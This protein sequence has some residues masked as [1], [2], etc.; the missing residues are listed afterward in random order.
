M[1]NMVK[2]MRVRFSGTEQDSQQDPN[3]TRERR[4]PPQKTSSF[5]GDEKKQQNWFQKQFSR[6]SSRDYDPSD[7]GEYAT[8]IAAA[9]FAINSLEEAELVDK[10]KIRE[11]SEKFPTKTNSKK[12]ESSKKFPTKTNSKK[13][14]GVAL[15]QDT[16]KISRQFTSKQSKEDQQSPGNVF[17]RIKLIS[18]FILN[19]ITRCSAPENGSV[20]KSQ[21]V[22]QRIP[23]TAV[24]SEKKPEKAPTRVPTTK[25][26]PTTA[27]EVD[28]QPRIIP[29]PPAKQTL[30]TA[31]DDKRK[32][33]PT[34]TGPPSKADAWMEAEMAKIQTRYEKMNST[35]LS[36]EDE[37][38]KKASRQLTMKETKL[39]QRRARALQ[40][41]RNEMTRIDQIVGGARAQV[42]EKRRNDEFKAKE[43]ANKIRATGKVPATCFCC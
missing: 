43:K 11:G 29:P 17:P 8:A 37:K 24:T 4:I 34:R 12:E 7:G 41:F 38:K 35:I 14:E 19:N 21:W 3:S 27:E 36:W 15:Q 13:E 28:R 20:E 26:T 40:Q 25:R 1:E 33:S 31:G 42:E 16:G 32:G 2:Q 23:E 6:Q 30:P 39:E 9:A 22:D 18:V 5:K 10:K